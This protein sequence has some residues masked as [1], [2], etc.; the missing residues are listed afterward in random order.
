M[1]RRGRGHRG[2][3][4]AA[5]GLLAIGAAAVACGRAEP[6]PPFE[7]WNFPAPIDVEGKTYRS[8]AYLQ[9]QAKLYDLPFEE[10]RERELEPREA[11]LAQFVTAVREL[12]YPTVAR[13]VFNQDPWESDVAVGPV[14]TWR[15]NFG[16]FEDLTVLAQVALPGRGVFVM[17]WPGL[18]E[19]PLAL[20]RFAFTVV[21]Y[22]DQQFRVSYVDRSDPLSFFVLYYYRKLRREPEAYAGRRNVDLPFH[23]VLLDNPK[24][25]V[26]LDFRGELLD[27]EAP[28]D[29]SPE[30]VRFYRETYAA[31]E[32]SEW[33]AFFSRLT[34]TRRRGEQRWMERASPEDFKRRK[35]TRRQRRILFLLDADPVF[36]VFTS[37]GEDEDN[38][39]LSWEYIVRHPTGQ[40]YQLATRFVEEPF[41]EVLQESA[42]IPEEPEL[43]LARLEEARALAAA[44]PA[45]A[46]E[47][48]PAP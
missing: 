23:Y 4:N 37:A 30:V 32:S 28:L 2:I 12:D 45:A 11:I 15:Q 3:R 10:F 17:E 14:D 22:P 26:A 48:A 41:E 21:D 38:P 16:Q 25:P 31:F 8:T 7:T 40:G 27:A 36:I 29:A 18:E 47:P 6:T 9:A 13:L 46:E 33:K 5:L 35:E 44:A 19:S 24:E 39:K 34:E 42:L 20:D 43:F 1:D